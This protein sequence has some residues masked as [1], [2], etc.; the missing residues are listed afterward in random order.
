MQTRKSLI[1]IALIIGLAS[2]AAISQNAPSA[3]P[4]KDRG[5]A[6]M[7]A[8]DTDK[9]GML[10]KAEVEKSSPRLAQAFDKL[11]SNKDSKLSADELKAGRDAMRSQGRQGKDG[12]RGRGLFESADANKDGVVTRQELETAL[13]Q[14]DPKQRALQAFDAADSN[15]DGQLSQQE[16]AAAKQQHPQ[17]RRPQAPAKPAVQP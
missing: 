1:V 16:L 11:D 13:A 4:N 17:Q 7:Q 6:R 14:K 10:S 12:K 5:A 8:A 9:D 2:A 3:G 15:K